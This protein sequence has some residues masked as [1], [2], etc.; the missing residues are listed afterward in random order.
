MLV[1]LSS[2]TGLCSTSCGS[3]NGD[4]VEEIGRPLRLGRPSTDMVA[5]S[6]RVAVHG[7]IAAGAIPPVNW[8]TWLYRILV[9]VP[10]IG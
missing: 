5:G 2:A 7:M 8:Q 4:A 1:C 9:S 6:T 10:T 3:R